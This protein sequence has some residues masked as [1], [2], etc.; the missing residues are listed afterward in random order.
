MDTATTQIGKTNATEAMAILTLYLA[1]RGLPF[2]GSSLMV[3]V[4]PPEGGSDD[5]ELGETDV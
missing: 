5:V 1:A 4:S 2:S 3:K